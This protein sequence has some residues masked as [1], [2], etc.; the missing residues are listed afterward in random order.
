MD[1]IKNSA[2]KDAAIVQ[3]GF[4]V[5]KKDLDQAKNKFLAQ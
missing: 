4:N 3:N 5:A 2:K 1:K